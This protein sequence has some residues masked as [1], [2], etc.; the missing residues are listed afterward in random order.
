M[1]SILSLSC[2]CLVYIVINFRYKYRTLKLSWVLTC[3][4]NQQN[5]SNAKLQNVQDPEIGWSM[6]NFSDTLTVSDYN[7]QSVQIAVFSYLSFHI[8]LLHPCA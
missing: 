7:S 2:L 8:A 5:H 6:F 4:I 1:C 3:F